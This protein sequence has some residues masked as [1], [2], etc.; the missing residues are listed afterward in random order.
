MVTSHTSGQAANLKF[1]HMGLS[2]ADLV[3]MENFYTEVLGFTVT[4]RGP[5]AGM[6]LVFLSRDPAEHH[7]IVL[8]TGKPANI[9]RNTAHP[10]FGASI[11][12]LSFRMG[13]IA[14]LR[15]IAKRLADGGGTHLFPANHGMAWSIYAHDP[16]DNNLEFYVDSGWYILQPFLVPLDLSLT[17]EEIIGAT[18]SMCQASAGFEPIGQW[19]ERIA[20]RMARFI[21]ASN[22]S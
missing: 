2:V 21:P 22:E 4:D 13:S 12:Q 5:A 1:S 3:V 10:Q 17:D 19:R 7:Q 8:A 11:N 6:E 14:D 9:P 16:E 18:R 15:D 20:G